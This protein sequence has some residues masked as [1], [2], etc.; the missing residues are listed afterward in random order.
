MIK[1]FAAVRRINFSYFSLLLLAIPVAVYFFYY[2]PSRELE[3]TRRNLRVLKDLGDQVKSKI[4]NHITVL[5]NAAG[6]AAENT[7][8]DANFSDSVDGIIRSKLKLAPGV[9]LLH[10][11]ARR[12]SLH[13]PG[14][15]SPFATGK[16]S[17]TA[18]E[19]RPREDYS[20]I[21]QQTGHYRITHH[22][23]LE[24]KQNWLHYDYQGVFEHNGS[25]AR[26][27]IRAR[28]NLDDL[29]Q[30]ILSREIFDGILVTRANGGV[31]FQ[32]GGKEL[33]A[34]DLET[35]NDPKGKPY[36]L[37]DLIHTSNTAEASFGGAHYKLFIQPLQ[38]FLQNQPGENASNAPDY[39]EWGLCALVASERFRAETHAISYNF[40]IIFLLVALLTA[41]SWPALKIWKIGPKDRL[42]TSD[43]LFL[44]LSV[45]VGAALLTISVLDWRFYWNYKKE[46]N[47]QLR[48]FSGEISANFQA[49]LER[50]L[51]Q[52]DT[53][54]AVFDATYRGSLKNKLSATDIWAA[55]WEGG[56]VAVANA[57][58]QYPF[59]DLV[60]WI[61]A[62]G[63]QI[64]K[65]S[66]GDQTTSHINVQDRPYFK[67]VNGK[68][69]G[70]WVE[71]IYSWTTGKNEV[72][73][74][75]PFPGRKGTTV[76]GRGKRISAEDSITVASMIVRQ[77]SLLRPIVP[78]G[79]GFCVIDRN[80]RVLFHSDEKRNLRE[81]FIEECDNHKGIVSALF[82]HTAK[83]ETVNYAGKDHR[84]YIRPFSAGNSAIYDRELDW[85]LVTFCDMV[86][87]RTGNLEIIT[88][89]LMLFIAY[90]ALFLLILG[91]VRIFSP[92]YRAEWLWPEPALSGFY[93]Q[94]VV[95]FL[96][97]I[98]LF[99]L[100]IF[101]SRPLE[102]LYT[103]VLLPYFVLVLSYLKLRDMKFASVS[104]KAHDRQPG[105]SGELPEWERVLGYSVLGAILLLL[106]VFSLLHAAFWRTL[107]Q[108]GGLAGV[109]M[110]LSLPG[111][112]RR[113]K[114]TQLFGYR[115]WFIAAAT[116]LVIIVA[117]LPSIAFFKIASEYE[118]E[119]FIKHEQ[120]DLAKKML[121]GDARTRA[122][123]ENLKIDPRMRSSIQ[124]ERQAL[125]DS[126]GRYFKFFFSSRTVSA[127][128][129]EA[130]E[131]ASPLLINLTL[132]QVLAFLRPPYNL[133]S[134]QIRGLIPDSS[135]DGSWKTAVITH[136]GSGFLKLTY[137][138]AP[139]KR[140]A[141]A[142]ALPGAGY[143]WDTLWWMGLAVIVALQYL[144]LRFV[145][146]RIIFLEFY[147]PGNPPLRELR[148]LNFRRN[149]LVLA[150]PVSGKSE[151]LQARKKERGDFHLIDLAETAPAMGASGTLTDL[152]LPEDSTVPLILDHFETRF[153]PGL[154]NREILTLLEQLVHRERRT[155][156]V[157]SAVDPLPYLDS[158]SSGASS[159][160]PEKKEPITRDDISRWARLLS[161][162][163]HVYLEDRGDPSEFAAT[164]A[165]FRKKV[166][167]G[168]ENTRVKSERK[169]RNRLVE[170]FERECGANSRLQKIGREIVQQLDCSRLTED[171]LIHEVAVRAYPFYKILWDAC[172][173]P[174]RLVLIHLAEDGMV[175]SRNAP[176]VQQLLRK[177][178]I[179]QRPVVQLMNESFRRFIAATYRPEDLAEEGTPGGWNSVKGPLL[180]ALIVGVGFLFTTQ[181][182]LIN[183]TITVLTTI[184]ALIPAM[185]KFLGMFSLQKSGGGE[186]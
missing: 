18:T 85:T 179:V 80:G 174:E 100:W 127:D 14:D 54:N 146:Q 159:S 47:R 128:S 101:I 99:F 3:H 114:Q 162:F 33:S 122:E 123:I 181:R 110:F 141:I 15:G 23:I 40:I 149:L 106:L 137:E 103:A 143:Y 58:L 59:Y 36:K 38:L 183:T 24:G 175:N 4:A 139:G 160:S 156:V 115:T 147:R 169:A 5:H 165:I 168:R 129:L 177:R 64:V 86:F 49:E 57:S 10:S 89:T 109:A 73:L 158:E 42:R 48:G 67:M 104:S 13:E 44:A 7:Y 150:P 30:P 31:I 97:L 9:E 52:L 25:Q 34:I 46:L 166:W 108:C 171:Q 167:E 69:E 79:F 112:S 84:V 170:V 82:G 161:H 6:H 61:D 151:L 134:A 133:T 17:D 113:F 164:T 78:A 51:A 12:S 105:G 125:A 74:S 83:W 95:G 102:N 117:V 35:L 27:T 75:K 71:S 157:L 43:V 98:A 2:V 87:I 91:A 77:L 126:L 131:K 32:T 142:T 184:A 72:I 8:A 28:T 136:K 140:L 90:A 180:L 135:E 94:M 19:K 60:V 124:Q 65:W 55:P 154:P 152:R 148:N 16:E 81:N 62:R 22:I 119:L 45:V 173:G 130:P 111:V 93:R 153:D 20:W 66:T 56:G 76:A 39:V 172:D 26:I 118:I 107:V 182:D 163:D 138:R 68:R 29:F 121:A 70:F 92:G 11:A 120:F 88:I 185:A 155:V 96:F 176:V 145:A 178:L 37:T 116:L 1:P 21:H 132:K 53:L 186:K 63:E 50:G 41:I 144:L